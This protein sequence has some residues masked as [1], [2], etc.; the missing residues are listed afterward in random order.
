MGSGKTT[1]GEA[2][3]SF[4]GVDFVDLDQYIE[5]REGLTIKEI[6]AQRGEE[7][8]RQLE[9]D[10]L[11]DVS[12]RKAVIACGGGTPCRPGNMELMNACGI[13]VWLDTPIEVLHR[14]LCDGRAQRPLIANKDDDKLLSFIKTNLNEREPYYSQAQYRFNS[15]RLECIEDIKA[16]TQN[17][18]TRFFDIH[19]G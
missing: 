7:A 10:A 19:K 2:L 15:E 6:F 8:F 12:T 5:Q 4:A 16:T 13:T 18:I 1:L 9:K 3:E 17:F 14:R 11:H